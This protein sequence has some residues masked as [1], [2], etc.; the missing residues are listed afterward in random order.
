MCAVR[1]AGWDGVSGFGSVWVGG[2]KVR[3][4][5]V[6]RGETDVLMCLSSSRGEKV[7]VL[8]V[9]ICVELGLPSPCV[10]LR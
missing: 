5:K 4:D 7:V 3:G 6:R 8:L 1:R 9:A 2:G 10:R